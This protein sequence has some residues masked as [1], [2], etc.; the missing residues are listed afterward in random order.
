MGVVCGW[1][2][3]C[4]RVVVG[5]EEPN[6]Q[7]RLRQTFFV[8]AWLNLDFLWCLPKGPVRAFIFTRAQNKVKGFQPVFYLLK[9][10]DRIKPEAQHE[11]LLARYDGGVSRRGEQAAVG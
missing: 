3:L 2:W 6:F 5:A 9:V 4:V 8:M 11:S 7:N 10:D 1:C